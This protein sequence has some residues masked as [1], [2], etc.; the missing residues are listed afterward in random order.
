M[1]QLLFLLG[2][3]L[4]VLLYIAKVLLGIRWSIRGVHYV[5]GEIDW[6]L[7]QRFPTDR[8]LDREMRDKY[9]PP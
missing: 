4:L 8:E 2:L 9:G 7:K 5:L 1:E 3:I 6:R